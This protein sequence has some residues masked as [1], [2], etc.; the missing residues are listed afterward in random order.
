MD[1]LKKDMMEILIGVLAFTVAAL[2][3]IQGWQMVN[4]RRNHNNNPNN[5]LDDKL[6]II[7]AK[8]SKME[9]S[10]GDIWDRVNK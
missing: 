1:E 9:Q 7:I 10:L 5:K 3:I 4:L 8:L 2:S 6:D